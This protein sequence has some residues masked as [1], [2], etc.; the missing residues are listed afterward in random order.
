MLVGILTKMKSS[1]CRWYWAQNTFIPLAEAYGGN[2]N[3]THGPQSA[4]LL[5]GLMDY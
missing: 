1:N 4:K 2:R 5:P 3:F